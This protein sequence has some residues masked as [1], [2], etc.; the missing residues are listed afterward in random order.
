MEIITH[1]LKPVLLQMKILKN[2]T[3]GCQGLRR[4]INHVKDQWRWVDLFRFLFLRNRFT[5]VR[6]MREL[7]YK[8]C[9]TFSS[10]HHTCPL[11]SSEQRSPKEPADQYEIGENEYFS[12][13]FILDNS[14]CSW[15]LSP[16]WPQPQQLHHQDQKLRR[17]KMQHP[18]CGISIR[19]RTAAIRQMATN[20]RKN[21]SYYI[22]SHTCSHIHI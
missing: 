11:D 1:L 17:R 2:K 13:F 19:P 16:F 7:D 8:N 5:K 6:D 20:L 4:V 22:Y 21:G 12:C 9:R 14:C 18:L 10:H 15:F 3:R